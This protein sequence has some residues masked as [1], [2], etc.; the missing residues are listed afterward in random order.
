MVTREQKYNGVSSPRLVIFSPIAHEDLGDPNLLGGRDD[1]ARLGQGTEGDRQRRAELRADVIGVDL[2]AVV[3][4]DQQR[5]KEDRHEQRQ[6]GAEHRHD[7]H[8][9]RQHHPQR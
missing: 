2:D 6:D 3:L 7:Q 4:V 5:R 8:R 9:Q 1:I